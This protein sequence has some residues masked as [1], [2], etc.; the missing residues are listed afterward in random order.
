MNRRSLSLQSIAPISLPTAQFPI[1][2]AAFFASGFEARST[3][4]AQLTEEAR[5]QVKYVLGFPEAFDVHSRE[6]NDEFF[7]SKFSIAPL[8]LDRSSAD[9]SIFDL[10]QL[11]ER[12]CAASDGV[13]RIL[14]DY[15][16]MTRA[17]YGAILSWARYG[18]AVAK[19]VH[20]DF[21]YSHGRYEGD[22]FPLR[23]AQIYSISGFE[24]LS[25]GT[26]TTT[27]LFG[28]GFDKYATMAV[29]DRIEPEDVICFV[30]QQGPDDPHA[31]RVLEQNREIISSS[32]RAAVPLPL[33]AVSTIHR[34]FAAHVQSIG[35]DKEV[36]IVPMGPKPHVL[37][38]LLVS[39]TMPWVTSLHVMGRRDKPVQVQAT[40]HVSG[41]RIVY[42][43]C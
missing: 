6:L 11:A 10:L 1:Y 8:I 24:G 9:R 40:G 25:V 35:R 14:V 7:K 16:V 15:S 42:S 4:L 43:A 18:A 5:T 26:R 13:L 3:H 19:E 28:L 39:Q 30:S 37:A 17:W 41:T 21:F 36:V 2:D 12:Q 32:G 23:I 31:A 33:A 29:Y 20:L 22:F 34:I 27:A 38:A